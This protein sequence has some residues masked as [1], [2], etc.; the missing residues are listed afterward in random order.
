MGAP[1]ARLC[2]RLSSG[3]SV[4]LWPCP[5]LRG[6]AGRRRDGRR[7]SAER[8]SVTGVGHPCPGF[9]DCLV[10][11]AD[12]ALAMATL[13]RFRAD[14]LGTRRL[15]RPEGIAHVRLGGE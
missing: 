4:L 9:G 7:M 3:Q 1:Y 6:E 13:V 8:A 10:D 14:Q 15:Q 12:S 11:E 5:F 2:A